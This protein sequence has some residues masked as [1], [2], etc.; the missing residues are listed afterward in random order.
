[1]ICV[2]G[3]SVQGIWPSFAHIDDIN[4]CY[5]DN[6]KKDIA[7]IKDYGKVKLFRYPSPVEKDYYIMN[8]AGILVMLLV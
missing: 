5:V 8:K 2:I 3:W 4:A 7:A 1:M 6:K